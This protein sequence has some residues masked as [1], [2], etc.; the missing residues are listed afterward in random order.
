MIHSDNCS[1]SSFG[2]APAFS[3]GGCGLNPQ[4][5]RIKD[6]KKMVPAAF[7]LGCQHV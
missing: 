5:S 7:F 6:N 1:D 4:P 3:E 2:T